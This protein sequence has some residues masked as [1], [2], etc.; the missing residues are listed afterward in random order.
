[1]FCD[2]TQE[3]FYDHVKYSTKKKRHSGKSKLFRNV[4]VILGKNSEIKLLGYEL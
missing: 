4:I 3:F 1:M 2:F